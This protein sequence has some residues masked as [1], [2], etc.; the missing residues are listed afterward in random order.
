MDVMAKRLE[1][2]LAR[3]EAEGQKV[4]ANRSSGK[5][6]FRIISAASGVDYKFLSTEPAKRRISVAADALGV[7]RMLWSAELRREKIFEQN[8]SRVADYLKWLEEHGLTLP[9]DPK[10]RGKIFFRQAEIEAGLGSDTLSLKNGS[11]ARLREVL[12]SSVTRLGLGVR[13]LPQSLGQAVTL[14]TY[15]RL[16]ERGAEERRVELK[17]KSS[18][19]QQ[20]YNTKSALRSFCRAMG[21]EVTAAVGGEFVVDFKKS[22]AEVTSRL[23][24]ISSRR[25]FQTEI[26]WWFDFYQRLVKEQSLPDDFHRTLVNLIDRSGLSL[27]VLSRLVEVSDSNLR[28]WYKGRST[29]HV[30]SLSAV[31]RMEA[32]FHL[33]A[34]TLI[35]KL[36]Y[37]HL[38]WG[39]RPSQLPDFLRHDKGLAIRVCRHLPDD[40]C[41]L[42]ADRQREIFESIRTELLGGAD[43]CSQ[44]AAELQKLPYRL[45]RW[46]ARL[47][48]EFNEL[49]Y[50][51]TADRPPIGMKRSAR[52]R[53]VTKGKIHEDLAY[54]FG[55]LCLPRD[56]ADARVRGLGVPASHLTLA[57]IACPLLVDWY[58]R[59]R[60]EVRSSYTA[61]AVGLL[62]NL[63]SMLA[64]DTGWLRQ[65]PQL[66][67]RLRAV[68]CDQIELVSP[69]LITKARNDWGAVCEAAVTHYKQLRREIRPLI[70]VGRDPFRNIG[71][72]LKMEDPMEAFA[73]LVGGMKGEIP[74]RDT[75]PAQHHVA[76]R[77]C[78][79]VILF[80]LTGLRRNTVSQLDYTG[81]DSGHLTLRGGRYVLKIPPALFKRE[82][83]SYFG[84][85]HARNDYVMELPDALGVGPIL[86]EYLNV[87]RPFLLN[88]YHLG[89]EDQPLF[90]TAGGKAARVPPTIVS[91]IYAAATER[92][93]AENKW[94]CSGI[95]QVGRHGPHSARHI[96]GTAAV[97]KSGSFQIAADANQQSEVT[98]RKHYAQFLPE[99]RNRRVNS[100]LFGKVD[101]E[102]EDDKEDG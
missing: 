44:R 10:S 60:C 90:V 71:G 46:P 15:E 49:A 3:L 11:A 79:L 99:D 1:K 53:S 62:Q 87:S 27:S 57:L 41:G 18:S 86:S 91:K 45:I 20:L 75:C 84:P 32:L 82:D 100:L 17:G 73:R 6:N 26:R 2:Y 22:A 92:H 74:N 36:R 25:K 101:R 55:A 76:I 78:A 50:F 8:R 16:L 28:T 85:S 7:K 68:S 13:V 61:W 72:I 30:S 42:P 63:A 21:L 96:R 58:I 19:D 35:N 29:P 48:K 14:I 67:A 94:R 88:K 39:I 65:Q 66:A 33:P 24:S 98:A 59:F 93:L 95:G 23:Q 77:N 31:S 89:C 69:E 40:F 81:D 64:A 102:E 12:Q 80:I 51:K 9:E 38:G 70:R 5:P 37:S 56:A 52:W 47:E 43:P 97:K 83:S 34:G 4:P 54:F